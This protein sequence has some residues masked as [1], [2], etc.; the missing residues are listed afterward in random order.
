MELHPLLGLQSLI[1][2]ENFYLLFEI[3]VVL[4]YRNLMNNINKSQIYNRIW[5]NHILSKLVNG[6]FFSNYEI[7]KMI[8]IWYK[9]NFYSRYISFILGV[10][11][12]VKMSHIYI[13]ESYIFW[14][15]EW[16]EIAKFRHN[17]WFIEFFVPSVKKENLSLRV[18]RDLYSDFS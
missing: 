3:V 9:I 12:L 10:L 18:G 8:K 5:G 16:T 14:K 2:K 11:K 17:C 13:Q 15:Q 1:T 4:I 7:I 6:V